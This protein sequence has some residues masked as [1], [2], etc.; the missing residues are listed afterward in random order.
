MTHPDIAA[1]GFLVGRWE[2]EGTGHYPT[3]EA[4]GYR[5]TVVIE[6]LPTPF[7]AYT[8]RTSDARTGQPRHAESG[9]FRLVDGIPELVVCQPTGI[10]EAHAGT[11]DGQT[12]DLG[13]TAVASTP[14]ALGKTVTGTRRRITVEGD[15]MH[16]LL[17]LAA[18]G[19]PLQA[20]LQAQ[21][22]RV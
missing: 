22:R 20:H 4:F 7:L 5:E 9:Y 12:L 18:V 8:Q 21:L 14:S 17:H 3:I 1:L 2:G 13:S 19:Q 15:S 10:V 6:P 11:L 16:Y